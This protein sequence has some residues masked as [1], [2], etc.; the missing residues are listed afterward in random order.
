M[1]IFYLVTVLLTAL[2]ALA[3]DEAFPSSEALRAMVRKD[4]PRL[5]LTRET[6]PQFKKYA[7]SPAMKKFLANM[8]CYEEEMLSE[9]RLLEENMK[10]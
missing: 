3:A 8:I 9:D 10:I 2:S 1:R 4:H 7:N 5:F 6:L